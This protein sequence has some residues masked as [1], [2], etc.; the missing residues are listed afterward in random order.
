[1][2]K[3][4][5]LVSLL[6][7]SGC[8]LPPEY[9]LYGHSSHY[10]EATEIRTVENGKVETYEDIKETKEYDNS[11]KKEIETTEVITTTKEEPKLKSN[12][13]ADTY[14]ILD[15]R[16]KKPCQKKCADKKSCCDIAKKKATPPAK[17]EASCKKS[18]CL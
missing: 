9:D 5:P 3:Y 17:K 15:N 10:I 18:C 6:I 8:D 7:I 1:M 2:K 16:N 13:K 4:L 11:G 12:N 14:I